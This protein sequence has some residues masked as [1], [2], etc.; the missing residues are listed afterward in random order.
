MYLTLEE[1][2]THPYC[3]GL[4][5]EQAWSKLVKIRDEQAL[6]YPYSGGGWGGTSLYIEDGYVDDDYV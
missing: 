6:T 4:T 1:F 2:K 5:E 3:K